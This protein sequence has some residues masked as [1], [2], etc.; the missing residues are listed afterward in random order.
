MVG[1]NRESRLASTFVQLADT[2]V[3][4][5]DMVDLLQSLVE[6]SAD[7]LEYSAA[8]LV[9]SD[10]AGA[11]ES[12]AATSEQIAGIELLQIRSGEGPA[13]E[14]VLTGAPVAVEDL[15]SDIRWPTF[16]NYAV[17]VGIASSY[18]VPLRLRSTIIGALSVYNDS[19]ATFTEADAAVAQS[20]ADVATISILQERALRE[21]GI[22]VEQ[23]Q[24][25]LNSRVIIEQAK[26][27]IS[28][29][30]KVDMDEAFTVLR[31]YARSNNLGLR[32]VAAQVVDRSLSL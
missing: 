20:L 11:L 26:G 2:L 12:V 16:G 7:L 29:T 10:G 1:N 3:V 21:S 27:V 24:H 25:A 23:L 6:T 22:A 5:F 31:S 13:I 18:S 8:G 9:L 19:V 17:G 4:G 28:Y 14:C 15:E 30:R 32:D